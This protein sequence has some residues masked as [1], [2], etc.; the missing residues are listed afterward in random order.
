MSFVYGGYKAAAVWGI[1]FSSQNV[2]F[3]FKENRVKRNK[4]HV[5]LFQLHPPLVILLLV[6]PVLLPLIE[7]VIT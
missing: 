5:V 4:F 3:F 7:N 6:P 2:I 1:S